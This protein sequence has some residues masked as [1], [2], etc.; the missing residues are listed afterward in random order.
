MLVYSF[1]SG[2]LTSCINRCFLKKERKIAMAKF[3]VFWSENKKGKRKF[4]IASKRKGDNQKEKERARTLV[5]SSGE[6]C[7]FCHEMVAK[8]DPEGE[9]IPGSDGKKRQHR[10]CSGRFAVAQGE[11]TGHCEAANL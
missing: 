2:S 10:A 5:L 3:I 1:G 11:N 9:N 8:G 7:P 6:Y 4:R